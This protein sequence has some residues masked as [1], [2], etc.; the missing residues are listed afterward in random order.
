MTT[1]EEGKAVDANRLAELIEEPDVHRRVL[2]KYRGPYALGV[3]QVSRGRSTD[4]ALSLSVEGQDS[5]KFPTEIEL[6]G[7][8]VPVVVNQ[9]WTVPQPLRTRA[10]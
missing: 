5:D 1:V 3:T 2:G 7:E 6:D 4:A 10:S 8:R 9:R